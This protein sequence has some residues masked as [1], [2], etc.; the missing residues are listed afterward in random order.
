MFDKKRSRWAAVFRSVTK[1]RF[2]PGRGRSCTSGHGQRLWASP[3]AVP[4]NAQAISPWAAENALDADETQRRATA[5]IVYGNK[6]YDGFG[7][8]VQP[9][10]NGSRRSVKTVPDEKAG[11]DFLHPFN[12]NNLARNGFGG[13]VAADGG[14]I[15]AA[16][17]FGSVLALDPNSGQVLWSK[18][19]AIPIREAPTAAE[20]RVFVVNSES[21]LLCLNGADGSQLWT[22]KGLPENAALLTSASPAVAGNLVFAPFPSGEI[23]AIDIK[24]G[25]PKWTD[26]LT[27]AAINV[28]D[29][30]GEARAQRWTA[31]PSLP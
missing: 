10:H 11:F 30:D 18:M 15:F 22:Q 13:G 1:A 28:R 5:S 16:T 23:T 17:G 29:R 12:S 21:E 14:K 6:I 20:G 24:T 27:K 25:Q 2:G 9:S 7:G 31:R 3:A 26:S 4:S 19:L 8:T